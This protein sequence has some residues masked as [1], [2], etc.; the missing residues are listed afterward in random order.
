[1]NMI[2]TVLESSHMGGSENMY[3]MGVISN[4]FLENFENVIFVEN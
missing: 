3:I 4:R 2:E 1:M